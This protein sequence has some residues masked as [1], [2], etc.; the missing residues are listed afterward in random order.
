MPYCSQDYMI[1]SFSPGSF[2]SLPLRR[3]SGPLDTRLRLKCEYARKEGET[4]VQE[5]IYS[6]EYPGSVHPGQFWQEVPSEYIYP[7][8]ATMPIPPFFP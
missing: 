3:Y 6:N 5:T 2:I 1:Y 8:P 4:V 7:E